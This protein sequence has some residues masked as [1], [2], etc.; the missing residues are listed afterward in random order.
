MNNSRGFTLMEILVVVALLGIMAAIAVPSLSTFVPNYRLKGEARDLYSQLQRARNEAVKT[1]TTVIFN[2]TPGVGAPCQGG[3]YVFTTAAGNVLVNRAM[4]N[5]IC[6]TPTVFPAG[7]QSNGL[8]SGIIGSIVLSHTA[9]N[10]TY[11][12]TQT[13][14]GGITLQ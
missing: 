1:N 4:P 13:F 7:F 3:R 14:A 11:S 5:G 12:L 2:F 9:N 10:R 6:L 8:P